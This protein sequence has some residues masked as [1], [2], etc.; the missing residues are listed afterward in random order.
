ML[1]K[2]R[3]VM[4]MF[5]TL[6][7]FVAFGI[8]VIAI[9]TKIYWLNVFVIILGLLIKNKG[10]TTLFSENEKRRADIKADLI[11][12]HVIKQANH[13]KKEINL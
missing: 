12:S 11:K 9:T 1:E 6:A 2:K 10:Y 13:T 3:K 7:S 5:W 8:F 4:K